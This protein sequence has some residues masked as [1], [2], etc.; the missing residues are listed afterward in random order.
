MKTCVA[1]AMAWVGC[2]VAPLTCADVALRMGP[3]ASLSRTMDYEPG[4]SP[5][6]SHLVFV[7]NRNGYMK[8]Y[9]M[10]GWPSHTR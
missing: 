1:V 3:P 2:A 10:R 5:D 8:I 4:W 6:G 7:S 9:S